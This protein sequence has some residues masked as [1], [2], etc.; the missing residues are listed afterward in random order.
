MNQIKIY[1][2]E[3]FFGFFL[4]GAPQIAGV[5]AELLMNNTGLKVVVEID[6]LFAVH[7]KRKFRVGN[8]NVYP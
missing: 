3:V 4:F 1:N 5:P 6:A 2:A 8:F 7:C